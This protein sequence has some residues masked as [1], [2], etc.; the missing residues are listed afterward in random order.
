[1]VALILAESIDMATDTPLEVELKAKARNL[2]IDMLKA[3][4]SDTEHNLMWEL[5]Q[6]LGRALFARNYSMEGAGEV[7]T[8]PYVRRPRPRSMDNTRGEVFGEACLPTELA[9]KL[10]RRN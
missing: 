3:L 1:M 8:E 2:A 10:A 4:D 6:A 7:N 5:Y 9:P